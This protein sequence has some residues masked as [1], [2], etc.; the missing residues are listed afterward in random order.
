VWSFAKR[1][2]D[3][4]LCHK[5]LGSEFLE[6][7]YERAPALLLN[8]GIRDSRLRILNLEFRMAKIESLR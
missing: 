2:R 3:A 6:S 5:L 4:A 7:V 8:F 1:E